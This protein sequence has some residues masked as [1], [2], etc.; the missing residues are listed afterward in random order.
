MLVIGSLGEHAD[1]R[2]NARK[3][4]IDPRVSKQ[5]AKA[6]KSTS[7]ATANNIAIKNLGVKEGL[8]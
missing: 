2:D 1:V 3:Q 8:T 7:E 5:Q 4:T 6:V